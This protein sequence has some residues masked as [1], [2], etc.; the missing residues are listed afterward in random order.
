ML[1]GLKAIQSD[2][3]EDEKSVDFSAGLH[4]IQN[5]PAR[6]HAANPI[7]TGHLHR[8]TAQMQ[9]VTECRKRKY[10]ESCRIKDAMAFKPLE[11]AWNESHL[12]NG[13]STNISGILDDDDN[14]SNQPNQYKFPGILNLAWNQIGFASV[15]RIGLDGTH[16]ALSALAVVSSVLWQL[17]NKFIDEE[18]DD[19]IKHRRIPSFTNYEDCTPW[20]CR[21]GQLQQEI[22]PFARYSVKG[23]DGKWSMVQLDEFR[24]RYPRL[25]TINYGTLELYASGRTCQY[26]DSHTGAIGG[27]RCMSPP[28]FLQRGNSSCMQSA[29]HTLYKQFDPD[30]MQRIAD[31]VPYGIVQEMQDSHSA[32]CRKKAKI[33]QELPNN[34]LG[35]DGRCGFHQGH[36]VVAANE[37]RQV[38][39]IHACYVTCS[40]VHNQCK[41][42]QSLWA[43]L[44]VELDVYVGKPD[45]AWVSLF[46]KHDPW[47]EDAFGLRL[48]YSM[49]FI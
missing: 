20:R 22:M 47:V 4:S 48:G 32:E 3:S 21:F 38:G 25:N 42:Q 15:L 37:E 19:L 11:N 33:F 9:Y 7:Y 27:F 10:A 24:R 34:F 39:D 8:S 18:V 49:R 43:V 40:Q 23:S 28:C 12:R 14:N 26:I 45:P 41:M 6:S 16:R 44:D 46:A 1:A 30:G 36:R 31:A 5:C 13:D 2:S 17:Q 35:F 29:T